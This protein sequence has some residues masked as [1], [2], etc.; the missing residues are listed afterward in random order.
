ME[1]KPGDIPLF[2]DNDA[3]TLLL[4]LIS[5]KRYGYNTR[6]FISEDGYEK[7]KAFKLLDSDNP[8][9]KM[10]QE[11]QNKGVAL[12]I[13]YS[14]YL[15]NLLTKEYLTIYKFKLP[16]LGKSFNE[17]TDK[18]KFCSIQRTNKKHYRRYC[19]NF[20]ELDHTL[21]L[22]HHH[23]FPIV[24]F[25]YKNKRYRWIFYDDFNHGHD[26]NYSLFELDPEQ[27]SL[28]DNLTSS[29]H[30]DNSNL[31]LGNAVKGFFM[32]Q[33]KS[34]NIETCKF[35]PTK[36]LAHLNFLKHQSLFGENKNSQFDIFQ[37]V[38]SESID[39]ISEDTL[40]F[41]VMAVLFKIIEDVKYA[42]KV[43]AASGGA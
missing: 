1:L 14:H 28:T 29:N 9:Y 2:Q 21:Y 26:F 25:L 4:F 35:V 23:R 30:V 31:L 15:L 10:V 32:N 16:Q 5:N 38:E 3:D 24:D 36:K 34:Y 18:V 12:P 7:Y 42:H 19:L 39:Q 11:L 20:H 33:L 27:T 43:A 37:T 13:F 40:V 6:T 17:E 8:N 41:S 22:F